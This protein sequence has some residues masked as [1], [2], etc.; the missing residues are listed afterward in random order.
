MVNCGPE[1]VVAAVSLEWD[2][3]FF[4]SRENRYCPF[5]KPVDHCPRFYQDIY[6]GGSSK[7]GRRKKVEWSGRCRVVL[8][9]KCA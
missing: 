9:V 3:L 7:S 6:P 1:R 4:C 5:R 8:A 2:P